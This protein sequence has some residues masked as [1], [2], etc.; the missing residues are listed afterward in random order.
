M[1]VYKLSMGF[2]DEDFYNAKRLGLSDSALYKL[3]GN[4]IVVN[5]LYY[6]FKEVFKEYIVSKENKNTYIKTA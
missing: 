2:D 6:I 4:S 3:A 5:C 1:N